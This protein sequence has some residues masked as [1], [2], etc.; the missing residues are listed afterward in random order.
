[1]LST[2][3]SSRIERTLR[4]SFYDRYADLNAIIRYTRQMI[5]AAN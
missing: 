4:Y 1:M 5:F 3:T 2:E